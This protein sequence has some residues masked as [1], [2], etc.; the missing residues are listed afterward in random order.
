MNVTEEKFANEGT[1][2]K[3]RQIACMLYNSYRVSEVEGSL[4]EFEDL[5]NVTSKA[6]NV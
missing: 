5:T 4:L 3:G 2:L 6:D 1:M